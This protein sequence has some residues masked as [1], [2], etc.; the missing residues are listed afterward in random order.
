MYLRKL[1]FVLVLMLFACFSQFSHA[2]G[3]K[4]S[5]S[6]SGEKLDPQFAIDGDPSTRWSSQFADNQW[7]IIDLGQPTEI[8]KITLSWEAACASDYNILVSND[9][10]LWKKVYEKK[11]SS[12]GTETIKI[13]PVK[14]RYVKLE[15]IK[16]ATKWGF[17]LFEVGF[18]SPDPIK[19]KATA[20]SGNDDY[21][22]DKAIDGN[23]QSRW[24]SSFEDNQWWQAEFDTPHKICGVVLKWENAYT[25][26]YNIEVK[27]TAGNWKK[28]YETTEGDG[29]TDI[30]YFE[31]VIA[32]ALKINCIQRG[33]GWGNSLWEVTFLDGDKPPVVTRNGAQTDIKLPAKMS[34]GGIILRWN[35]DYPKSFTLE[36]SP[37]GQ[38]WNEVFRTD[39]NT[40]KQDWI[41][42]KAASLKEF[43]VNCLVS[44]T[45][46]EC[47]LKS[48]EPKSGEEQA[49][50][51]KIYQ[52]LAKQSPPK[53]QQQRH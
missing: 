9:N 48:F 12:G 3:W 28:V 10:T 39:K 53:Q 5:A 19:A 2:A 18:N 49:T 40:S 22:A 33:T 11:G 21:G 47:V 17:S 45:G 7:F 31:P 30:I 16:R 35:E 13:T 15:L 37:D 36:A 44:A 34:L 26:I 27:D 42:F 6:S 23:M 51:I 52:M 1:S 32:A 25:E 43:R 41:Y 29:N 24:S 38:A 20:S 8:K 50:P 46:K 4:A 14:A